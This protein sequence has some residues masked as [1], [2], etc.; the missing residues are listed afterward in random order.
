MHIGG[1]RPD[2]MSGV[3]CE[4][5]IAWPTASLQTVRQNHCSGGFCR[6]G[7]TAHDTKADLLVFDLDIDGGPIAAEDQRADA[8]CHLLK[9]PYLFSGVGHEMARRSRGI[10]ASA[11]VGARAEQEGQKGLLFFFLLHDGHD[12]LNQGSR[13][14]R[15]FDGQP[16]AEQ[17]YPLPDT[18]QTEVILLN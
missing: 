13:A 14:R 7:Y 1:D 17:S 4:P 8:I 16:T 9:F 10:L 11:G 5:I 2:M 15:A 12:D 3:A 18:F 6:C